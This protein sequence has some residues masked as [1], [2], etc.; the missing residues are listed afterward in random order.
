MPI[1]T[2]PDGAAREYPAGVSGFDVAKAIS[3]SLAK[4]T[5]AMALDR[6][7]LLP[8]LQLAFHLDR[9]AAAFARALHAIGPDDGLAPVRVGDDARPGDGSSAECTAARHAPER[10][11]AKRGTTQ[12]LALER[13]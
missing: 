11:E 8:V 1:L 13:V 5:V 6:F 10:H 9:E 3:P 12:S 7:E 4:R 2:F